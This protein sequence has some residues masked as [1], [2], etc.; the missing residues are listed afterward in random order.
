VS[1]QDAPLEFGADRHVTIAIRLWI[2]A[3]E[4]GTDGREFGLR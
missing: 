1:L 2:L 4:G 3:L